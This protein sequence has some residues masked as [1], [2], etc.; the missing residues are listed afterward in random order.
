[1]KWPSVRT[2]VKCVLVRGTWCRDVHCMITPGAYLH[3]GLLGCA[4]QSGT[5]WEMCTAGWHLVGDVHCRV[6]PGGKCALQGGTTTSGGRAL[7]V[8]R[9]GALHVGEDVH[10]I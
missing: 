4:L 8:G 6:A 3:L 9:G 10:C 7:R 5:W 1:M 2:R